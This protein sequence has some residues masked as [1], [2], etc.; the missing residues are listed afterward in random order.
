MPLD[1]AVSF[2]AAQF[3]AV[4]LAAGM[5]L[6]ESISLARWLDNTCICFGIFVVGPFSAGLGSR[7]EHEGRNPDRRPQLRRGFYVKSKHH[8]QR[9]VE[10]P[11]VDLTLASYSNL[12]DAH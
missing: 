11:C 1:V 7:G 5:V 3:V 4:I 12:K 6:D 2:T 9:S 10:P 8:R